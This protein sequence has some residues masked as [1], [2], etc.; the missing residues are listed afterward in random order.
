MRVESATRSAWKLGLRRENVDYALC[1]YRGVVREVYQVTDWVEG[2]LSM[3]G[4][5]ESGRPPLR[6][7]RWEFVGIVSEESI[8]KKY[9]GKSVADYFPQGN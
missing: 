2:G 3:R 5:D 9:I 1:V 8:R 4:V 6:E 7:G